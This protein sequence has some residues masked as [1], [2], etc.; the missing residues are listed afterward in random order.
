MI[1]YKYRD[2]K[3]SNH[4]KVL[5]NL[6]LFFSSPKSLNDPFDSKIRFD[7][8][9]DLDNASE[10]LKIKGIPPE[11]I[12]NYIL[13]RDK[14]ESLS[15]KDEDILI[16]KIGIISF[17]KTWKNILLWSHY[18]NNHKGFCVGFNA[19]LLSFEKTKKRDVEYPFDNKY[20]IIEPREENLETKFFTKSLDW[21]YEEEYRIVKI[22]EE[23]T[24][25]DALI[26][27]ESFPKEALAE[28]YLG[29]E[30]E[31]NH[32]QEILNLCKKL[33]VNVYQIIRVPRKFE[34]DRELIYSH[35]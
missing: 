29:L 20:P 5:N 10:N 1:I 7:L 35:N 26:R 22:F 21:K 27:K 12:K 13:I 4:K 14:N 16:D 32:K 19:D 31:E 8:P 23:L 15:S 33:Q 6:E 34:I 24:E 3:D 25:C 2:W 17:S 28:V 9:S 30:M 11:F 18:S